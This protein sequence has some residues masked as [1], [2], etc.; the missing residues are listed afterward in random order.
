MN[1]RPLAFLVNT[2]SGGQAG[3]HLFTVL[4]ARFPGQVYP[5][6]ACDAVAL[7]RDLAHSAGVLVACGGDG[8]V[9][10]ALESTWHCGG[11]VPVGIIP[12]GTGNDL[13]R[14][15]GWGAQAPS[16]AALDRH[17]KRLG[18]AT[19]RRMDR[20]ILQGPSGERS[21]F[22]YWSTGLDAAVALRFHRLRQDKPWL[23]RHRLIN[24]GIYGV[25][26]CAT[27]LQHLDGAVHCATVEVPAQA[28]ALLIT[29]IRHWAG[30]VRLPSVIT[31]DDGLC[32]GFALETGLG[33][34]LTTLGW[35]QPRHL[36]A[37]ATWTITT[38]CTLPMQCDGE[39][40][41]AEAGTWT[42]RPGGQVSVLAI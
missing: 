28:G 22:N 40:F 12:L 27:A 10:H 17:L 21:W 41:L 31:D 7:G 3:R 32:D 11:T 38:T 24:L 20:W 35:R 2:A 25:L 13:S 8:T 19:V 42:V 9:S 6:N 18:T 1:E 14:Q 37:A 39:P 29:N 23:F 36:A 30:G 4:S 16:G 33:L 26:G 5:I 34:A 15:L